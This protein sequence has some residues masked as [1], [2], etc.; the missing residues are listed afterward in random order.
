MDQKNLSRPRRR[1]PLMRLDQLSLSRLRDLI[2]A[3]GLRALARRFDMPHSSVGR[4]ARGAK[5]GRLTALALRAL[6]AE[7]RDDNREA[8]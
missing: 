6:I 7:V 2:D 5:V 1:R 4:V 3:E 8:A